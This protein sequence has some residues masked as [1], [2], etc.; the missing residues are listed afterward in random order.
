MLVTFGWFNKAGGFEEEDVPVEKTGKAMNNAW[1]TRGADFGQNGNKKSHELNGRMMVFEKER[2]IGSVVLPMVLKK[3]FPVAWD[4]PDDETVDY[5]IYN[6]TKFS[7]VLFIPDICGWNVLVKVN[8][9]ADHDLL[10]SRMQFD[11]DSVYTQMPYSKSCGFT[12]TRLAYV[13]NLC[14]YFTDLSTSEI[15]LGFKDID[16][17]N[18]EKLKERPDLFRGYMCA[19]GT[20][21][22][23]DRLEKLYN[24]AL[25]QLSMDDAAKVVGIFKRAWAGDGGAD[26]KTQV[27]INSG[28]G[29]V[30]TPLYPGLDID[31]ED[32]EV[33]TAFVRC[34]FRAI[35]GFY[36]LMISENI[37]RGATDKEIL[38]GVETG[39]FRHW[40]SIDISGKPK[41]NYEKLANMLA[42]TDPILWAT[43]YINTQRSDE[44]KEDAKIYMYHLV[45]GLCRKES[46]LPKPLYD[47][48]QSWKL[49][50]NTALARCTHLQISS[51][52]DEP[53]EHDAWAAITDY[54]A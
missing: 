32:V 11:T 7:Y 42:N 12:V 54:G 18:E 13:N 29:V 15:Y 38:E 50:L 37:H 20:K 25:K 6:V 44:H 39:F 48:H 8:M 53:I 43:M 10:R 22:E 33:Q 30:L 46:I 47:L 31:L 41:P 21:A 17:L 40:T 1:V 23:H 2:T 51:E 5:S 36:K 14:M 49:I 34:A 28:K 19:L 9:D 27:L 26:R 45:Q 4:I 3:L 16:V 52:S 24:N 35:C